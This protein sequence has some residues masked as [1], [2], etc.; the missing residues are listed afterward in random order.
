M[1]SGSLRVV[2][3]QM[4]RAVSQQSL[5]ILDGRILGC[6]SMIACGSHPGACVWYW[7]ASNQCPRP[8]CS[9]GCVSPSNQTCWRPIFETSGSPRAA[10]TPQ[11]CAADCCTCRV[12]ALSVSDCDQLLGQ[13][14]HLSGRPVLYPP[15][16]IESLQSCLLH[17][18]QP[19]WT[20]INGVILPILCAWH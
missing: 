4:C 11:V 9:W 6:S 3:E 19:S 12:L 10:G 1:W 7:S 8:S 15:N 20:Y 18:G 5:C 14:T 2:F 17:P 13:L 16:S